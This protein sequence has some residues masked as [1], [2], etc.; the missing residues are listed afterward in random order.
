MA[1]DQPAQDAPYHP[2]TSP[3]DPPGISIRLHL[4]GQLMAPVLA[5][6]LNSERLELADMATALRVADGK[7]WADVAA[8]QAVGCA[9]ALMRATATPPQEV[10]KPFDPAD[11]TA[12]ERGAMRRLSAWYALE[13]LPADIQAQV[14]ACS[15]FVEP[16]PD[17]EIP[18]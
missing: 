15:A 4:A 5:R 17:T 14:A 10:K 6:Y 11:L 12:D 1:E 13:T 7:T 8:N 2:P 9:D 3:Y 16:D 18:F